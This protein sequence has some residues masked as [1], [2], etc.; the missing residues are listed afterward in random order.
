M[1]WRTL[2]L[3]LFFW[4]LIIFSTISQASVIDLPQTGQT[5]SYSKNENDES[6]LTSGKPWPE[7]RFIKSNG[8][9]RDSMTGLVWLQDAYCAHNSTLLSGAATNDWS[10]A[11]KYSQ[12]LNDTSHATN[13]PCNL[14]AD[15]SLWRLANVKEMASLLRA[16]AEQG[17]DQWLRIPDQSTAGFM[18]A[19][20]VADKIWTS[21]TV[22]NAVNQ[23]WVVDLI[24]GNIFPE[25]KLSSSTP[26]AFVFGAVTQTENSLVP[27]TGQTQSFMPHDDGALQIGIVPPTPRF[28]NNNDG[29]V[30]DKLT[31]LMWF[32]NSTCI[33]TSNET[34][35]WSKALDLI[36]NSNNND[37]D[38]FSPCNN[39]TATYDDWRL[40]NIFELMS[41]VDYGQ[42][43]P[44][45]AANH[46]F[47]VNNTYYWSATSANIDPALQAWSISFDTGQ[48]N[49]QTSKTESNLMIW[50]VRGQIS[51]PDIRVD[52]TQI[53]FGDLAV[54]NEHKIE[55]LTIFNNGEENL[56]I[57]QIQWQDSSAPS[58]N[59][60][61]INLDECSQSNVSPTESCQLSLQFSPTS[62]GQFNQT[63]IIESNALD[64]PSHAIKLT[65]QGLPHVVENHNTDKDSDYCFIATA[66][67]GSF[68]AP[69][70]TTLR[71]FRD[72]F[73]RPYPIG[74]TFI[75]LYYR[76]SPPMADFISRHATARTATQWL[77][78]PIIFTIKNPLP[79]IIINLAWLLLL[80][81]QT[82][83]RYKILIVSTTMN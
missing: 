46:P 49:A 50:P 17:I 56:S 68:L 54:N 73:L 6:G 2:R 45:L 44:A 41:L 25:E 64:D 72:R 31:G 70:V 55:I 42:T 19:P 34:L 71:Q 52:K 21:T 75:Q 29:T 7:L 33:N 10:I 20:L 11:L 5:T 62:E 69:E 24:H 82:V 61:S 58:V 66:T 37:D 18:G 30:I 39:Y 8:T 65:G 74:Q 79:V 40:P 32:Q 13:K 43:S 27:K 51:Y 16:G 22:A 38:A 36:H 77:L 1:R 81:K 23:A 63:I 67:Y 14:T 83:A 4:I 60:F 26:P 78:A 3:S 80:I 12:N 53:D 35:N 76:Y 28:V 59:G 15:Y 48:V 47:S 9:L 57:D